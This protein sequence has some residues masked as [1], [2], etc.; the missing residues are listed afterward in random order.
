MHRLRGL[1]AGMPDRRDQA[2]YRARPREMAGNQRRIRQGLAEHY[3]QKGPAGRRQGMGRRAG[4]IQEVLLAQG[5]N[6]RLSRASPY[7]ATV[8]AQPG[9]TG[10]APALTDMSKLQ[11]GYPGIAFLRRDKALILA[12]NVLYKS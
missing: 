9:T 12:K 3:G 10:R 6:R 2:G 8:R 11:V 1:R 7:L 4:Q 5:R